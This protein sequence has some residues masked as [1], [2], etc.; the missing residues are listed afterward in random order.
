MAWRENFAKFLKF[1]LFG[2]LRKFVFRVIQEMVPV[3]RND[4][5]FEKPVCLHLSVS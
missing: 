2:K 5:R 1:S 4:S 3:F